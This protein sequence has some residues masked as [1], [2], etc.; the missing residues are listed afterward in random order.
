MAVMP[1]RGAAYPERIGRY[2]VLCPIASGGM[3]TVYLARSQAFGGF[4]RLVALKLVHP[5]LQNES[6]FSVGLI[7]EAKLAARIRHPNVVSV[8]DVGHDTAGV[9]LVMDYVE[10]AALS[11]LVRAARASAQALP[12]GAALRIVSD[13]LAGL[14]AAHELTDRR[15]RPV[16][17]VHRDFSPQNVLVGLDGI[18]R[19][20]DFG[21]AKA[22]TRLGRTNTGKIKGKLAYMAPEQARAERVDR[23]SDVWS[24]GVVLWELIAGRRLFTGTDIVSGDVPPLGEL[25]PDVPP[26]LAQAVSSALSLDPR[27][28]P[29]TA[30]ELRTA[31]AAAASGRFAL[32]DTATVA[33]EVERLVGADLDER[34]QRLQ[35]AVLRTGSSITI[36]RAHDR[37]PPAVTEVRAKSPRLERR[38]AIAIGLG[39]MSVGAL[40]SFLAMRAADG[41]SVRPEIPP[42]TIRAASASRPRPRSAR[43]WS[44]RTR[45]SPA[46][47]STI[48]RS[49]SSPLPPG[50]AS[51]S[52]SELG[53]WSPSAATV[54]RAR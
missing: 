10:G 32:A 48:A 2:D 47:G 1:S 4:E 43:S 41:E 34:R 51:S 35:E 9:H 36:V 44:R 27:R 39:G 16:G 15:G 25:V 53:G 3:A 19:L 5:H 37:D 31:I 40:V 18:A 12:V 29:A 11:E 38:S 24:A 45:R 54:A 7:D 42:E 8:L 28:R 13:A 33:T 22:A 52:R 46:C 20:T 17:L 30:N 21:V 26:A 14:H 6:E 23:R 49:R 50:R